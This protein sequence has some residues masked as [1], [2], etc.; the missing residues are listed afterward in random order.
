MTGVQTCALPISGEMKTTFHSE[1]FL[2]DSQILMLLTL[3]ANP[4]DENKVSLERALLNAGLTMVIGSSVQ[5]FLK[6]TI[7]L[8]LISIT[9]GLNDKYDNLSATGH[10]YYYIKIGKYVFRDL[11]VTATTGVNNEERSFGL[12]YDLNSHIGISAWY[13][14]KNEKYIG[15]DWK[16]K[17]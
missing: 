8:D 7:G 9:S 15:T 17:F 2:K 1:P 3:H 4:E 11:M 10:E 6:D 14:N 12:H 13:N 16:F 5:S